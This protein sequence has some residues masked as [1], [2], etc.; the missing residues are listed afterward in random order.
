M[1]LGLHFLRLTIFSAA[2][3]LLS[4]CAQE[5]QEA[6]PA[7][8]PPEVDVATP[9]K[10]MITDWDEYTGRFEAVETVEVRARVTGHL[11]EVRFKDGQ[12]VK[13]G[14]VLF[15]I[16]KRRFQYELERVQAQLAL[17]EKEYARA[18]KLSKTNVLAR[19]DFDR[20]AEELRVARANVNEARLALEFTEVTAPID[21]KVSRDFIN[22]GNLVRENETVL[23]RI[24]S[25]DPIHFY[26][27]ASQIQLMKYV[28]MDRS[29]TRPG[30]DTTANPIFIKLPDEEE[31]VHEGR[32]DFVDNIVDPGTGTIQGRALVPNPGAVIYPGLFGRAKLIGSGEY[33]ALLVPEKAINTDQSRKFVFV[34]D[35]DNKAQRAYIET[36]TRLDDGFFV[37]K[38]GLDEDARV[39]VSGIQ[40]IRMPEQAVTPNSVTL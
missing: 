24:V 12:F 22:V 15:V 16:D 20:R 5:P 8:T 11:K 39:V 2:V 29:G 25:V 6:A 30:S 23:T 4:A 9:V 37:V 28:R 36:G 33:E 1:P 40:R 14:E 31:Y 3:T 13:Q 32:M 17:A 19:E 35:K 21:G 27:E 34:V 10:R 7:E 26:F 18:E 38:S